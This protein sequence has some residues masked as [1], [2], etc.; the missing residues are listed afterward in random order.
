MRFAVLSENKLFVDNII[1][2]KE[3]QKSE[4]ENAL[5]RTLMDAAPLG[6]AI[7]DFYNGKAWTR[8]VDGEQV[9]LPIGDNADVEEAIAI[10]EGVE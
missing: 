1:V 5:N 10:L 8:N 4:L 9:A 3:S 2:A 7:G 6:M